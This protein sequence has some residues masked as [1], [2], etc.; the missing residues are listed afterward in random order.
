MTEDNFSAHLPDS[1][2]GSEDA[3]SVDDFGHASF[4]V[5]IWPGGFQKELNDNTITR[6]GVRGLAGATYY[7]RAPP[8]FFQYVCSICEELGIL[9]YSP[10]IGKSLAQSYCSLFPALGL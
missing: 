8:K 1:G 10:E 4:P 7:Q 3:G 2:E 9:W 6:K 5:L